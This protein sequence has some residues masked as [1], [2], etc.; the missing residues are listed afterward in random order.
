[1]ELI[2]LH[3]ELLRTIVLLDDT[4]LF[5]ISGAVYSTSIFLSYETRS[6]LYTAMG[7][8]YEAIARESCTICDHNSQVI[9]TQIL[10]ITLILTLG[11]QCKVPNPRT[12]NY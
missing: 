7:R 2:L 12:I 1:M 8:F 9:I 11:L 3:I 4:K 6:R 5:L 10:N